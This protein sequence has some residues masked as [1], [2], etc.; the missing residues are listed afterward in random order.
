M[1]TVLDVEQLLAL[2][3]ETRSFEV[4]APGDLSDKAYC[5]K[6]ARASMAMGNL[7]DGGVVC[8]GIDETQMAAMLPGLSQQQLQD[9]SDFDNVSDALRAIATRPSHS[10]RTPSQS[11]VAL[12]SS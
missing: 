12:R 8:L 4:K 11:R 5:A 2:G 6:V 1:L 7:R 3:H 10:A 9:W